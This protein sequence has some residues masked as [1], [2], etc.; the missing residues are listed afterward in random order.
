LNEYPGRSPARGNEGPAE[1]P[2]SL[3][4]AVQPTGTQ[5]PTQPQAAR[6]RPTMPALP[7]T[8]DRRGASTT[9]APARPAVAA[10]RRGDA[11]VIATSGE[12]ALPSAVEA[13]PNTGTP[14][15]S[16][17][18]REAAYAPPPPT[19][20]AQNKADSAPLEQPPLPRPSVVTE[21][22]AGMPEQGE[23]IVTA[24]EWTPSAQE[25][26]G[27]VTMASPQ[28]GQCGVCSILQSCGAPKKPCFL[29]TWFQQKKPCFLKQCFAKKCS[30]HKSPC[31]AS[32]Q[33]APTPQAVCRPAPVCRPQPQMV[34]PPRPS[35]QMPGAYSSYYTAGGPE[36]TLSSTTRRFSLFAWLRPASAATATSPELAA[37]AAQPRRSWF[38]G[39]RTVATV[40]PAPAAPNTDMAMAP[41]PP[42]V[43]PEAA[44]AA[45]PQP[46]PFAHPR[47]SLLARLFGRGEDHV[48]QNVYTIPPLPYAGVPAP[49]VVPPSATM[50]AN[51]A[52]PAAN[53]NSTPIASAN[54]SSSSSE[55]VAA[56]PSNLT[57]QG[58]T[59][60]RVAPSRFSEPAQR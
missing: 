23:T 34:L 37:T 17:P 16:T 22:V 39:N 12:A 41:P 15:L 56:K 19:S 31:L 59:D 50:I 43:Q 42:T 58:Q 1:L 21:S 20:L 14:G 57:Q 5:T 60:N 35:K 46:G 13:I 52:A 38:G 10:T 40:P 44:A 51:N 4:I 25:Y 54:S 27:P 48:S 9:T 45:Q 11:A 49:P 32:P 24:P 3:N 36:P 28:S 7:P 30:L 47:R 26:S 29:K 8:S 2:V 55:S 18:S 53:P 6:S 33:A